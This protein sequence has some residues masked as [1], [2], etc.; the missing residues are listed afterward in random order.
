MLFQSMLNHDH[1]DIGMVPPRQSVKMLTDKQCN[2]LTEKARMFYH[3]IKAPTL[4]KKELI[5]KRLACFIMMP[6]PCFRDIVVHD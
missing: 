5:V 6:P 1:A 3:D 2:P 4:E